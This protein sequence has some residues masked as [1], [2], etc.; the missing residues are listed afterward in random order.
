MLK[1]VLVFLAFAHFLDAK[2]LGSGNEERSRNLQYQYA[3]FPSVSPCGGAYPQYQS[4]YAYAAP[5]Q[6]QAPVAYA[7]PVPYP[8]PVAY[9][10]FIPQYA[11]QVLE[12]VLPYGGGFQYGGYPAP[13]IPEPV[14]SGYPYQG[15]YPYS[16]VYPT[17]YGS[18]PDYGQGQGP[19]TYVSN[20]NRNIL[21]PTKTIDFL[22][23]D[24][25]SAAEGGSS[26]SSGTAS[27]GTKSTVTHPSTGR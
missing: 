2:S 26:A 11:P 12:P 19:L 20:S 17:S 18:Y 21:S 3:G 27:S 13:V 4:P 7:A 16:G 10:S 8:A 22:S 1:F 6:Y 15:G 23:N 25:L 24:D 5:V 14:I 9:P